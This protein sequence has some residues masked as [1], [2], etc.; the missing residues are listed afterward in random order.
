MT[1]PPDSSP[2]GRPSKLNADTKAKLLNAFRS[3]HTQDDAARLAGIH[4]A[5]LARWLARGRKATHGEY[6]DFC[7]EVETAISEGKALLV[8][9]VMQGTRTKPELALKVLARRWPKEWGPAIAIP[10]EPFTPP[11][12]AEARRRIEERLDA[13]EA[14]RRLGQRL[15]QQLENAP[16]ELKRIADAF[17]DEPAR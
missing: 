16:P 1:A 6:R 5:T 4:P 8:G 3:P 17:T 14:R 9:R 15:V 11:D 7:E 12:M 10:T 2:L 13:I